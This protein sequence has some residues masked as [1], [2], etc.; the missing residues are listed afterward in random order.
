MRVVLG[1]SV[2]RFSITVCA[3]HVKSVY[4]GLKDVKVMLLG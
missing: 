1:L 2:A 3:L 4:A